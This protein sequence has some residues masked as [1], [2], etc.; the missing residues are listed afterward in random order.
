MW[1]KAARRFEAPKGSYLANSSWICSSVVKK[2]L[3][4]VSLPN[5][6]PANVSS[7][8]TDFLRIESP[9]LSVDL[10]VLRAFSRALL[11]HLGLC[12]I[13]ASCSGSLVSAVSEGNASEGSSYPALVVSTGLVKPIHGIAHG[14][15]RGFG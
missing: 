5:V 13:S 12:R 8:L 6:N 14:S 10:L 2:E 9:H 1:R 15:R 3:L 11:C 4:V 7:P